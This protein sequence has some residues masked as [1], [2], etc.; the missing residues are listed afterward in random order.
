MK[1]SILN[2]TIICSLLAFATS[3]TQG[4]EGKVIRPFNE[5]NLEGWTTKEPKDRSS[6]TV[7][8][9]SLDPDNPRQLRVSP[10]GN[11]L[12]NARERGVDIYTID[13]FGDVRVELEVMVPQGS[14]S[15]IYLMGEY[16]VQVYDSYGREK[17]GG[18][19]MGAI[20]GAAPPRVNASKAPGEWQTYLIEFRAPRFD[21]EGKKTENA[22]FIKVVLNDRTLHEN[23]EMKSQTPGGVQGKEVPKGPLMF[24]GD[25]GP[26]AYRNIKITLLD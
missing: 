24:Q 3:A 19:D 1:H 5:K 13:E 25:H 20:Y 17:L 10:Q 6:W 7:G 9:A 4:E 22:K 15:G 26:V 14:N 16:E 23:V 11:E 8:T 12:I 21:Q 18:G 2:L